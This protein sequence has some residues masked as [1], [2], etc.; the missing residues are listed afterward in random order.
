MT[1]YR[2]SKYSV[3][4]YSTVVMQFTSYY[5]EPVLPSKSQ[6]YFAAHR[7]ISVSLACL[8]GSV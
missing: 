1:R 6:I 8:P 5:E 4:D 3:L 2:L 7:L